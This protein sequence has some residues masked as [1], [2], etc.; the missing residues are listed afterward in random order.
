MLYSKKNKKHNGKFG[1]DSALRVGDERKISHERQI[2][3]N[4][5]T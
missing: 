5:N 1:K 4:N 2:P 3:N